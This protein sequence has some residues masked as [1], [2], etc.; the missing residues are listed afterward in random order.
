MARTT[1]R[2]TWRHALVVLV[3][4]GIALVSLRPLERRL[5]FPTHAVQAVTAPNDFRR[6]QT[7]ADDGEPVHALELLGAASAPVVVH[8][9][10][11]RETEGHNVE[12]ARALRDVGLGVVLAEYRGYGASEGGSPTERGLYLDAKAVLEALGRRGLTSDRI[13]LWGHSLGT[14][15]AA[16][17][18]SRGYGRALVLVAPFTSIPALVAD[19]VPLLPA[20]SLV[21]N[22]FQ[23][24]AK[25][26]AIDVPT[27]VIHGDQDEIV[28]LW[29]GETIA[30]RVA[31][32]RLLRVAGGHHSDLFVRERDRLLDEVRNLARV[33]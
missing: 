7:T 17:M 10:N 31:D 8:F 6:L 19:A 27:L 20:S 18:A 26:G 1:T 29:M 12:L 24:L 4:V 25:S 11:N 32:A 33:N 14:G 9:H 23:T 22:E 28:P 30:R 21:F 13:I 5:I 3:V 15:V 2:G 16:E